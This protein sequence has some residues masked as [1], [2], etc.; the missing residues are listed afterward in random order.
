MGC[1]PRHP[2]EMSRG[3]DRATTWPGLR[4]Q[5]LVPGGPEG[6]RGVGWRLPRCQD[7]ARRPPGWGPG[8]P[9]AAGGKGLQMCESR[10]PTG[11][12]HVAAFRAPGDF[13]PHPSGTPCP[14][15]Q[16]PALPSG[17]SS[18]AGPPG[19][20]R[21]EVRWLGRSGGSPQSR[22]AVRLRS[23]AGVAWAPRPLGLVTD[24]ATIC[25]HLGPLQGTG[26]L[27]VYLPPTSAPSAAPLQ[28]PD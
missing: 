16:H 20:R 17:G 1:W 15:P 7:G 21:G 12:E 23:S 22:R 8:W 14:P 13:S 19:V 3:T 6:R 27:G 28:Q 11:L 4:G 2:T 25:R 24:P 26:R 10:D 5:W 18:S 9:K